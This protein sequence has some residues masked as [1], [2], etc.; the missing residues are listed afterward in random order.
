MKKDLYDHDLEPDVDMPA[1]FIQRLN[2]RS[3]R[4]SETADS[5]IPR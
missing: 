3:K 2:R 1:E 4:V 5:F